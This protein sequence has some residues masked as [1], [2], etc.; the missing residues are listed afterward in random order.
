[1]PRRG[2]IT[3][4]AQLI[5]INCTYFVGNFLSHYPL[6]ASPKTHVNAEKSLP[7]L[8]SINAAPSSHR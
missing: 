6:H 8:V 7:P 1:M 2:G 3:G 5:I 4:V